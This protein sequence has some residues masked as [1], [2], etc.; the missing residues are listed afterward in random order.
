[1]LH[2]IILCYITLYYIILY[3]II[4]YYITLCY[5]MLW[6][7]M[8]RVGVLIFGMT[9][10]DM[11]FYYIVWHSMFLYLLLLVN[12]DSFSR[13]PSRK[14]CFFFTMIPTIVLSFHSNQIAHFCL[15]IIN[16]TYRPMIHSFD[17][18]NSIFDWIHMLKRSKSISSEFV[19]PYLFVSI[20]FEFLD[21]PY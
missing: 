10:F 19:L 21:S 9:V 20:S 2:Y 4:L 18:F 16:V 13:I 1:M 11:A 15:G 12:S 6:Y 8:Q 14:M 5:I 7:I 17:F 3:H